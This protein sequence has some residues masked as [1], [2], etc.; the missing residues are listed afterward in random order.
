MIKIANKT[1]KIISQGDIFRD[2]EFIEK[3]SISA[4]YLEIA[5]IHFPLVIVLT[6]ECDLQ[7]DNKNRLE[8]ENTP[9][10]DKLLLSVLVAPL[11]YADKFFIGEH[12]ELI[13]RKMAKYKKSS[14]EGKHIK[15]NQ[16]PRYH[17]LEFPKDVKIV[18]SVI[19][20]KHYF[21]I[22]VETL[23]QLLEN[24]NYICSVSELFRESISQ[25]FA[26]FLSR[27]GLPPHEEIPTTKKEK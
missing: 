4:G 22:N 23:Y 8:S 3:Y 21:S 5:L 6:Q 2:I 9:T 7:L 25:R 24:G 13:P 12:L 14:T 18:P 16:N 10:Q 1:N 27:I 20:F 19:D 11:Y 15:Q 17:Y 26:N